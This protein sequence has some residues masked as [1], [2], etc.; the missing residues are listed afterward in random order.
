[1]KTP[2]KHWIAEI[3]SSKNNNTKISQTLN[4][5]SVSEYARISCVIYRPTS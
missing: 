2:R 4:N 5:V 1:M 3:E